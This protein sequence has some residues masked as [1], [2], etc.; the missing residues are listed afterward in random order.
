MDTLLVSNDNIQLIYNVI[1]KTHNSNIIIQNK[2]KILKLIHKKCIIYNNNFIISNVD[3]ITNINEQIIQYILNL[4]NISKNKHI[5]K[6]MNNTFDNTVDNT[7]DNTINNTIV[8]TID[9]TINNTNDNTNDNTIDDNISINK[10]VVK[11]YEY[12][13]YIIDN[14]INPQIE[15]IINDTT[16]SKM[17]PILTDSIVKESYKN[18]NE[19][20]DMIEYNICSSKDRL[21]NNSSNIF[22]L[23]HNN[24]T[25]TNI[26]VPK[27]NVY[28]PI[29][30]LLAN[31][32]KYILILDKEI[33]NNIVYKPISNIILQKCNS[34]ELDNIYKNIDDIIINIT[35]LQIK[36]NLSLD[37]IFNKTYNV[38]FNIGDIIEIKLKENTDIEET[39]HIYNILNIYT[40]EIIN[41]NFM[42]L[43]LLKSP[44]VITNIT[45]NINI[46]ENIEENNLNKQKNLI[47]LDSSKYYIVKYT[48]QIHIVYKVNK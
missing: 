28:H 14:E 24:I 11:E 25:I 9:N 6:I 47:Q 15:N 7:I 43:V 33:N 10:Q 34:I 35:E 39:K 31:N 41:N 1:Y 16:I 26:I 44:A 22:N 18:I 8:N 12:K 38:N 5:N 40:I 23:N 32:K 4:Y 27:K 19:V 45:D 20:E 48:N 17:Y 29:I 37:V 3:D 42:K 2:Q 13:P 30:I 46:E 36:L 21:I